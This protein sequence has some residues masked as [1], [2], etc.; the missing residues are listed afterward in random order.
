[1]EE[2]EETTSERSVCTDTW[3]H[4]AHAGKISFGWLYFLFLIC[5]DYGG[6]ETENVFIFVGRVVWVVL[7]LYW[8]SLSSTTSR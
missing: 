1:M 3:I 8:G 5:N 7:E 2:E 6:R 4:G